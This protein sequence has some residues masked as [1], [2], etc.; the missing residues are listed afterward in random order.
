MEFTELVKERYSCK[1]FNGNEIYCLYDILYEN[2]IKN[3][4]EEEENTELNTKYKLKYPDLVKN[5]LGKIIKEAFDKKKEKF[6]NNQ[7]NRARSFEKDFLE[8]DLISNNVVK[9]NENKLNL[10]E[11][12]E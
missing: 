10:D 12:D 11:G 9:N 1:K 5:F 8:Q 4:E 2:L 6:G 3:E 7:L